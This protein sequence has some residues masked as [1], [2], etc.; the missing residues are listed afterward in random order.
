MKEEKRQEKGNARRVKEG[1]KE[2]KRQV[3]EGW[4]LSEKEGCKSKK[5]GSK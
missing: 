2:G 5:E 4:K 3:K 1:W